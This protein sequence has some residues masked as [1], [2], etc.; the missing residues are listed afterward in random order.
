MKKVIPDV[1]V[2]PSPTDTDKSSTPT[3]TVEQPVSPRSRDVERPDPVS[4]VFT[5]IP[6]LISNPSSATPVRTSRH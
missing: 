6:K 5:I 4:N 1:A 3:N 2:S